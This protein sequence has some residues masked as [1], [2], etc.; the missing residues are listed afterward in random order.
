MKGPIQGISKTSL[1]K[2]WK[3]IR[4]ELRNSSVRD[5]VD[6]LEYDID[7]NAWI[8]RLLKRIAERSYEPEPPLR[9]T[10]GKSKGLSR[11]MTLPAVPDLV[12]YR[13][14]TEHLYRKAKHRQ[15]R[16]VYFLRSQVS[17]AQRTAATEA[18]QRGRTLSVPYGKTQRSFLNWLAY[19]QYRKRLILQKIHPFLVTTDITNFFDSV[20][21]D[22]VAEA[23]RGFSVP[24]RML[25][26][27]FFLLERLAVREEYAHSPAIGLAVDEF[28]CSRTL[29]HLVLF[30]YDDSM[31]A[32]VG[33]DRY[34]R[35]MDDQV[36]GV[37]SRANG[38]VLL[39]QIDLSLRQ[40]HL[41]PNAKKSRILTLPEARRHYH[42]DINHR[43]DRA[44]EMPFD[45]AA[46][47]RALR[48]QLRGI[49]NRA[50]STRGA[51]EWDKVLRRM[52]RLA[53]RADA[54]FLRRRA[55]Q[56]VLANPSL[57]G[58]VCDYM[59]QTGTPGEYWSFTKFLLHHAEQVYPDVNLALTENL[60]RL[61]PDKSTAGELRRF[62]SA[63][64]TKTPSWPGASHCAAVA[65]LLILRYGDGRS[66][67]TLRAAFSTRLD[68][69]PQGVVRASAIV[70]A[71]HD[72][73]HLAGLRGVAARLLR[74]HLSEMVRFLEK[75]RSYDEVP[76]RFKNRLHLRRDSITGQH[77]IDM[78]T[79]LTARL[80]A[81]SGGRKVIH[82]LRDWQEGVRRK[83]ISAYDQLLLRRLLP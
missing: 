78:R 19:D 40:L 73:R 32:C 12:L 1:W 57:V 76:D 33:E 60:L 66:L 37:P 31:V 47:R 2:A 17:A 9:F 58:R 52:Y 83:G 22:H 34:V 6:Y 50:K 43:L 39:G 11:T 51:G 67:S 4:K 80:L 21:H 82:W 35:W 36:F 59:R 56:D 44:E 70:Y 41:T 10:L 55:P 27:L 64:L 53:G 23:L 30:P 42:L 63:L 72:P 25:G 81:L 71:S 62:A 75:I 49:W 48:L 74:N 69:L 5:V 61:E 8:G 38:L 3:E 65:P 54:Q 24:P 46:E 20:L 16:H 45:T 7:P 18:R 15:R 77:Y 68:Q 29:A 26:L 79:T 28:D 14:I 13:A